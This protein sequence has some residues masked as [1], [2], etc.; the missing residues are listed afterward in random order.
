MAQVNRCIVIGLGSDWE[1]LILALSPTLAT[2]STD[3]LS[4]LL[5]NNEDRRNF[6]H[7]RD[8][9][10]PLFG[11]LG[12]TPA[13]IHYAAGRRSPYTSGRGRGHGRNGAFLNRT[14][15]L[16]WNPNFFSSISPVQ[17][18]ADGVGGRGSFSSLPGHFRGSARAHSGSS[19]RPGPHD[20]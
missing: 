6:A 14:R 2:M 15:G 19:S 16:G 9:P 13:A 20:R 4:A 12:P 3:E 11:I 10:A 1:P 17:G 7:D 5:L 8:Q 18:S